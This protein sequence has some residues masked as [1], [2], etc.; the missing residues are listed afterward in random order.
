MTTNVTTVAEVM[1]DSG[2]IV[3]ANGSI[4]VSWDRKQ[5]LHVWDTQQKRLASEP[6]SWGWVEYELV[7]TLTPGPEDEHVDLNLAWAMDMGTD[8]YEEHGEEY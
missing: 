4:L 3:Y 5:T 6:G 7:D 2:V 1:G 8:W